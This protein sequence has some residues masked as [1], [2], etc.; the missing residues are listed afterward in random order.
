MSRTV[1]LDDVYA[2]LIAA[3]RA[4]KIGKREWGCLC[5]VIGHFHLRS[6]PGTARRSRGLAP[7]PGA[8]AGANAPLAVVVGRREPHATLVLPTAC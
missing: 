5:F 6:A 7:A 2:L 4:H 8:A 1:Q 3:W